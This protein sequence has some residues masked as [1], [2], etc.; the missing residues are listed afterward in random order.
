[1]LQTELLDTLYWMRQ[2]LGLVIG[3]VCGGTPFTGLN[4]FVRCVLPLLY[5]ITNVWYLLH[6]LIIDVSMQLHHHIYHGHLIVVQ[7]P[8]VSN[9]SL[10]DLDA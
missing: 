9:F 2:I 6:L 8:E 7:K 1:M 3:L 4:A 10:S 5:S